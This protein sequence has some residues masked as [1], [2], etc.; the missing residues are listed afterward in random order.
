MDSGREVKDAG[1]T[2]RRDQRA[3]LL[4]RRRSAFLPELLE[5]SMD[6]VGLMDPLEKAGE[7]LAIDQMRGPDRHGG[8]QL[9]QLAGAAGLQLEQPLE[10]APVIVGADR[11]RDRLAKLMQAGEPRGWPGHEKNLGIR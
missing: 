2:S 3:E 1:S 4:A 8:E 5:K 7:R 10:V 6:V 11:V 9:E